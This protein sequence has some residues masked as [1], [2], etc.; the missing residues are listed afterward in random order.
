MTKNCKKLCDPVRFRGLLFVYYYSSYDKLHIDHIKKKKKKTHRPTIF[1]LPI[2]LYHITLMIKNC[3]KLYGPI[4][5][6]GL[7]FV[8]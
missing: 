1:Y 3:K 5:F 4:R 8:Y 7:S 2:T 6:H